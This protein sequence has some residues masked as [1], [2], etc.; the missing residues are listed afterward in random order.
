MDNRERLHELHL[1][2]EGAV[3]QL[4]RAHRLSVGVL[5]APLPEAERVDAAFALVTSLRNDVRDRL[6]KLLGRPS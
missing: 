6:V 5:D 2:L 3:D 1:A 4:A